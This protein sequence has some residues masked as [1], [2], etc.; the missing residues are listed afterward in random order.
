[1]APLPHQNHHPSVAFFLHADIDGQITF[2]AGLDGDGDVFLV[3][4]LVEDGLAHG[5]SAR[6]GN[7]AVGSGVAQRIGMAGDQDLG[8]RARA[9]FGRG[10]QDC[11]KAAS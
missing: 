3:A 2:A 10:G 6:G 5:F 11:S 9:G 1:M 4:Q 7:G 8:G